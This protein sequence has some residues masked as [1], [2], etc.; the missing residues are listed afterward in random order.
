MKYRIPIFF[1]L[2]T[3]A[4]I[5]KTDNQLQARIDSLEKKISEAYKPGFGELM[6]GIQLHHAKLWFA[7]KNQNWPLAG[8]E[9]HEMQ[10]AFETIEKYCAEREETRAIEMMNPAID[11]IKK[12]I[13]QQQADLFEKS[14]IYLTTA[15]NNCHKATKHEFNNVIIPSV[16]PISNQ[17]FQ[18]VQ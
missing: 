17:N 1:L 14:Y 12:S 4:C 18:P 3:A 15:C 6:S 7:G 10:E 16:S 8:F 2:V 9:V 13:E 11:S 5:N